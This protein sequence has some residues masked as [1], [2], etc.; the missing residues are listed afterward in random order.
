MLQATSPVPLSTSSRAL[1]RIVTQKEAKPGRS[2]FRHAA[3]TSGSQSTSSFLKN[4]P[5]LTPLFLLMYALLSVYLKGKQKGMS[6]GDAYVVAIGWLV[7][8]GGPTPGFMQPQSASFSSVHVV[9]NR[10]WM[11]VS[12]T[13]TL[14]PSLWPIGGVD[15][16]S[17]L[18]ALSDPAATW[19]LITLS[20]SYLRY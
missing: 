20:K 10:D 2:N 5:T 15:Q 18:K 19:L 17:G 7:Q 3:C 13:R 16:E 1:A 12:V 8:D 9:G 14:P 6:K 4:K 11:L